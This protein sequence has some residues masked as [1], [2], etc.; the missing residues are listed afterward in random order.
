MFTQPHTEEAK[1][2]ISKAQKKLWADPEYK[3][4]IGS[5]WGKKKKPPIERFHKL[6]TIDEET[7]CWNWNGSTFRGYGRFRVDNKTVFAHRWYWQYLNE[8]KLPKH[9]HICHHC[10]NPSCVN[11]DHLFMGTAYDNMWDAQMKGRRP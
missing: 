4:I 10:D 5:K 8:E 3:R 2:K 9:L 11:P 6:Y 7:G 1:A